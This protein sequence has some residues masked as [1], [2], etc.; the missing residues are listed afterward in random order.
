V[1]NL[2]QQMRESFASLDAMWAGLIVLPAC[3]LLVPHERNPWRDSEDW[4]TVASLSAEPADA[5]AALAAARQILAAD[6]WQVGEWLPYGMPAGRWA[7]ELA[8]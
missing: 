7:A 4:P 1:T 6:G 5:V 2:N 8:L 3:N